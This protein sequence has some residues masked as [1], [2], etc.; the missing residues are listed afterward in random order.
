M[1]VDDATGGCCDVW[2][3]VD[4]LPVAGCLGCGESREDNRE[5]RTRE[6]TRAVQTGRPWMY[7]LKKI[8]LFILSVVHPPF[9]LQ[10][11]A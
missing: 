11:T 10:L 4:Q 3:E 2:Q 9:L 7:I 8:A 1:G 5:E 6:G